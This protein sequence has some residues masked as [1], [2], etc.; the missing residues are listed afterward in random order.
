MSTPTRLGSRYMPQQVSN[1]AARTLE[2][3]DGSIVRIPRPS[4]DTGG[5]LLEMELEQLTSGVW[6]T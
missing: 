6:R 3:P 4:A 5:Q 1:D 2:W